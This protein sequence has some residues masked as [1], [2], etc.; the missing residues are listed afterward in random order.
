MKKMILMT[1]A[2]IMILSTMVFAADGGDERKGKFI[3]KKIYKTCFE[4]GTIASEKPPVSPDAKTQAQWTT[5]FEEKKFTDMGCPDEW[6]KLSEQELKDIFA[7]LHGHA[8]DS[9][10]P[11]KCK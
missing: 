4:K 7:Y 3:Y 9:P 2:L 10:T 6:S 5:V 8:A 11:A 1:T